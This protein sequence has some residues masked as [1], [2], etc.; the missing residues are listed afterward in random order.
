MEQSE[1]VV[2][3][4]END[5]EGQVPQAP[6][7]F[8]SDDDLCAH[9]KMMKAQEIEGGIRLKWHLGNLI[10]GYYKVEKGYGDDQLGKIAKK[11]GWSKSTLQKACQFAEKYSPEQVEAL[12]RGRF[13][14]A[15]RT[16]SQNLCLEAQAFIDAYS[17]AQTPKQLNN[18]VIRLRGAGAEGNEHP[19]RPKKRKEIEREL[20]Q[21]DQQIA[22]LTKKVQVLEKK[23]ESLLKGGELPDPVVANKETLSAR[24]GEPPEFMK[25]AETTLLA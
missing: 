21:K 2:K 11:T 25:K 23:I 4:E 15:W 17:T 14:L 10:R 24:K 12:T 22:D 16:I 20:A 6:S 7:G 1:E 13:Q 8:S 18:V 5:H 19:A 3:I 9:L